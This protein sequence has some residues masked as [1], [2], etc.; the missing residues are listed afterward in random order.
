[1][2]TPHK[3]ALVYLGGSFPQV[4]AVKSLKSLDLYI[5]LVDQSEAPPCLAF[6]D[7]FIK[8]SIT[9]TALILTELKKLTNY[10]IIGAYGVA[11]YAYKTVAA[12][13]KCFDIKAIRKTEYKTLNNKYITKQ[14]I[15]GSGILC[16]ETIWYGERNELPG[17]LK[18]FAQKPLKS[19]VI[20]AVDQNN[21]KGIHI[22]HEPSLQAFTD[23]LHD[24]FQ[25]SSQ[26]LIEEFIEGQIGNVDVLVLEGK[27][28]SISTTIRLNDAD[29]AQ[30]CT[31][32]IQ[33]AELWDGYQET[34][35][36][37]AQQAARTLDYHTGPLTIDL[38]I[39][40]SKK[41]YVIEAS[42]HFHSI[43]S[44]ILRGNGSPIAAYA[45]YLANPLGDY[46]KYIARNHTHGM[47]CY[48]KFHTQRGRIKS[49]CGMEDNQFKKHLRSYKLFSQE[50]DIINNSNNR[51]ELLGLFWC[52]YS[53]LKEKEALLY[54]L[55][56]NIYT[57]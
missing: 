5:I 4:E 8:A 50:G 17:L 33:P 22:L 3:K 13:H 21:S 11:D 49:I 20:K 19:C 48:Q 25:Y 36:G 56:K 26:V 7:L 57:T 31:A 23:G 54:H 18:E 34:V 43:Q 46:R 32:M 44:E 1:M 14:A 27:S 45:S 38:L 10:E 2:M 16:P 55:E 52:E 40:D 6:A 41:I 29:T 30:I 35:F 9:D 24:A 53:S 39:T 12:I 51:K 15:S 42:P 28:H 37:I 47:F